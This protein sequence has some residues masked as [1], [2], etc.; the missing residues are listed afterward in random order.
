MLITDT[1]LV[2]LYYF[3]TRS[4]FY[5]TTHFIKP[6]TNFNAIDILTCILPD[7]SLDAFHSCPRSPE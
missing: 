1:R 3:E 5:R 4:Y 7:L 6:V 2:G